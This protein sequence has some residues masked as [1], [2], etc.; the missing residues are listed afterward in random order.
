MIGCSALAVLAF[1]QMNNRVT[2]QMEKMAEGL[3]NHVDHC[4]KISALMVKVVI[5]VGC[6]ILAELILRG[7]SFF[8]LHT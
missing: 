1:V 7:L 6:L 5:S 2:N 4:A 8:H 3:K